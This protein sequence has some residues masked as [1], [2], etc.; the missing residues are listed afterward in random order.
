[1]AASEPRLG[2][3]GPHRRAAPLRAA[4]DA[5]RNAGAASGS[6]REGAPVPPGGVR[7]YHPF[8]NIRATSAIRTSSRR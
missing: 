8:S 4:A 7:A 6:L 3:G 1:M 2:Y 5:Q